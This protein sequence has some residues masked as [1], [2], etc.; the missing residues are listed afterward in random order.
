MG[1]GMECDAMSADVESK[2]SK[3]EPRRRS[4]ICL[5]ETCELYERFD[6]IMNDQ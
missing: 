1:L 5:R 3:S 6:T 4:T 2:Y